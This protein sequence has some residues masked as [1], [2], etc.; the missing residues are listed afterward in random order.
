MIARQAVSWLVSDEP[1]DQQTHSV[2]LH[3][4]LLWRASVRGG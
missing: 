2:C 1:Q 4:D 3:A